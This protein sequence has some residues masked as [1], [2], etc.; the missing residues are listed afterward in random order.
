[1]AQ[2][3]FRE[4]TSSVL[5]TVAT[6]QGTSGRD[7]R[8][9]IDTT[10]GPWNMT[11][12]LLPCLVAKDSSCRLKRL[13]GTIYPSTTSRLQLKERCVIRRI[14]LRLTAAAAPPARARPHGDPRAPLSKLRPPRL[15]LPGLKLDESP[16]DHFPRATAVET[17]RRVFLLLLPI[18][19][20][21]F[22]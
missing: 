22:E 6:K 2:S 7:K 17:V 21:F 9:R 15:A 14:P 1:M 10:E 4:V 19:F 16:R 5:K 11:P 20:F 8:L 3:V 18:L 13:S 12:G